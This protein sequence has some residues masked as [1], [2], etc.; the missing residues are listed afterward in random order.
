MLIKRFKLS[1]SSLL[2]LIA[3]G[4]P[5]IAA[6]VLTYHNDNARTGCNPNEIT[7]TPSNV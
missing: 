2:I 1:F 4:S 5:V 7:L 3:L 6:D